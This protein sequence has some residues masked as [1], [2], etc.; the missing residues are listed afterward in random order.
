MEKDVYRRYLDGDDNALM[1]IIREY[2]DGL[3]M[4]LNNYVHDLNVA[5]DLCCETFLCLADKKPG[6]RGNSS[7]K[8]FLYG[9][10]RKTALMYI[11]RSKKYTAEPL[12]NAADIADSLDP[13][14]EYLLKE[15][16]RQLYAAMK[17]LKSEHSQVLWLVYFEE[18]S[19]KEIAAV[20]KKSLSAVKMLLHRARLALKA[21]LEKEGF[22]YENS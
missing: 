19:N 10:G 7:F 4:Y 6:F 3:T 11:R 14:E 21:E 18:L 15:R 9:I 1:E 5:D 13:E 20:M 22:E 17:R 2:K 12:E 16:N 8:T